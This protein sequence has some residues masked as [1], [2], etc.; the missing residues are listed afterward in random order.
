MSH[1]I[2][3]SVTRETSRYCLNINV[4]FTLICLHLQACLQQIGGLYNLAY[5][6]ITWIVWPKRIGHQTSNLGIAGSS[7]VAV[8]TFVLTLSLP[9]YLSEVYVTHMTRSVTC[10]MTCHKGS[11]AHVTNTEARRKS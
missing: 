5:Q 3:Y 6:D 7:P 1:I 2:L 4:T 8:R 9:F 11:S 10:Y